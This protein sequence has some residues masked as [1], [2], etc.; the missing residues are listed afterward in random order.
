M[1]NKTM[2][3]TVDGQSLMEKSGRQIAEEMFKAEGIV[4]TITE[5][6]TD[7]TDGGHWCFFV[8]V[9]MDEENAKKWAA[10]FD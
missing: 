5:I 4:C 7:G 10:A 3:W 8:D 6:G 9:E 1:I 2:G